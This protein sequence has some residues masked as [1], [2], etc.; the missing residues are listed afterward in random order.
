MPRWTITVDEETDRAN[1]T[2]LAR[3]NGKK[4]DL[5][6]FVTSAAR[7]AAFWETVDQVRDKNRDIDPAVIE[8]E[9][10]AAVAEVRAARHEGHDA[11][12]S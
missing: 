7:R 6:Q 5:S 8:A 9:V 10:D 1:R 12:R 3:R 2:H 11:D 4:G